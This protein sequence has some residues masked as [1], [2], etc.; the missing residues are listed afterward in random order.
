MGMLMRLQLFCKDFDSRQSK[1]IYVRNLC[2][3]AQD[4]QTK[5]MREIYAIVHFAV[6]W[7]QDTLAQ[8]RTPMLNFYDRFSLNGCTV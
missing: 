6:C 3:R 7:P 4:N 8:W 2:N 1:L 5:F